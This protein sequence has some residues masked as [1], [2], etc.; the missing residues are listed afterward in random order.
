MQRIQ[1]HRVRVPRQQPRG[2]QGTAAVRQRFGPKKGTVQG[3]D[4]RGL[5]GGA[6]QVL[7]Q[8][9]TVGGVHLRP[10]G[11]PSRGEVG[12]C[13]VSRMWRCW[14]SCFIASPDPQSDWFRQH[15]LKQALRTGYTRRHRHY[16]AHAIE[17]TEYGAVHQRPPCLSIFNGP[18]K[19]S[20]RIC[21]EVL[22]QRTVKRHVQRQAGPLAPPC[23]PGL[24]PQRR[25]LKRQRRGACITIRILLPGHGKICEA[26]RARSLELF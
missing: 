22:V 20:L 21:H 25:N 13:N 8:N 19:E 26:I 5:G 3:G 14:K 23:P 24:L 15:E 10:G 4:Q 7:L 1:R 16:A 9:V 18:P 12:S 6:Q 11:A 17:S 2:A